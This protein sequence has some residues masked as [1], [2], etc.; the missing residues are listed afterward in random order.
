M[1]RGPERNVDYDQVAPTYDERFAYYAGAREG[2][3][4]A[5]VNLIR[6]VDAERALDVGYWLRI[7]GSLGCPVYGLDF[8][9][10]MLRRARAAGVANLIRGNAAA[11]PFSG[12]MLD[13]TFCVNALH[14]FADA[15]LFIR[16]ARSL[17]RPGGALA[18]VGM[19]PHEGR[20]RWYLYE[21]FAGTRELDLERYPSP[22]TIT[23]WM[24]DAGFDAVRWHV[25]ERLRD[26]RVGREILDEPMLQKNATSQLSLLTDEQY[27]AGIA[28]IRAAVAKAEAIR[29]EVVFSVDISL[30]M[31]AGFVEKQ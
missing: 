23:N 29:E 22:G 28:R 1:P 31:V 30:H 14:H 19:N 8:S 2:V 15:A 27:S 7:L 6:E 18:V 16:E 10:G 12:P 5:L 24:I 20:D 13:L 11:L 25:V 9:L 3:G 4:A 26:N 17:L 21:Y